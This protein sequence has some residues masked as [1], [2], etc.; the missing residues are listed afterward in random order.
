MALKELR[1]KRKCPGL[2]RRAGRDKSQIDN[3][4]IQKCVSFLAQS[5]G[6][7]ESKIQSD[8][9]IRIMANRK[10]MKNAIEFM[11]SCPTESR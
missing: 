10:K 3:P 11:H 9:T 7:Q 6:L 2:K 8:A 4:M 5:E 1:R